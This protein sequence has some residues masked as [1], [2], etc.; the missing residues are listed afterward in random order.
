MTRTILGFYEDDE[1]PRD[2]EAAFERG[3]KRV[4]AP[5]A[6]ATTTSTTATVNMTWTWTEG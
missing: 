1:D 6:T 4:T 3:A 5:P 2:V